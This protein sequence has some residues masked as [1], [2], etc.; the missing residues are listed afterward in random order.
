ML[1]VYLFSNHW[2]LEKPPILNHHMVVMK[3]LKGIFSASPLSALCPPEGCQ[4]EKQQAMLLP[5][6]KA[7]GKSRKKNSLE[8]KTAL[9]LLRRW[10]PTILLDGYLVWEQTSPSRSI[11]LLQEQE[12]GTPGPKQS[13]LGLSMMMKIALTENKTFLPKMKSKA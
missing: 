9:R 12:E 4:S 13:L 10:A 1:F 2:I 3:S 6:R 5:L 11:S 7:E 8:T